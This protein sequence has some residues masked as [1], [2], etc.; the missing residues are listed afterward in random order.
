MAGRIFI[1]YRR[2]DSS[3]TAGRLNDRLALEFG[4]KSLFMDVDNMPAGVDFVAHLNTRVAACDVFLAVIGPHWLEAKDASGRRRLADPDDYVS[5]E[6]A[7]A[8]QRDIRVIPVL[9][10]GASV[11]SSDELPEPLKPLTRRHAIEVRNSHFGRDAEA[12]AEKVREALTSVRSGR[13][14]PA[15]TAAAIAVVLAVGIAIYEFGLP[16]WMPNLMPL[17]SNSADSDRA[18]VGANVKRSAPAVTD[19]ER[20]ATAAPTK[21]GTSAATL[22]DTLL[23]R[24][25]AYSVAPDIRQIQAQRFEEA[26]VHKAIAVSPEAHGLWSVAGWPTAGEA[27]V[28]ALEGCQIQYGAPCVLIA[29]DDKITLDAMS[30]RVRDMARVRYAA[31]FDLR[32]IPKARDAL[33]RRPEVAEYASAPQP[34]AAALHAE[35]D[36]TFITV[37]EAISQYDAEEQ[38]LAKC[39][40]IPKESGGPCFL[41]AVGNQVVLPQRATKPLTPRLLDALLARMAAYSVP[42][43]EQQTD[44]ETFIAEGAHKAI[45]VSPETHH[46]FRSARWPSAA[47]AETGALEGCQI[48]Y[49]K[50]CVL[51]ATDDKISADD[52]NARMPRDMPRVRYAGKFDPQQIPRARGEFLWRS[53]VANYAAAPEPKAAAFHAY[54]FPNFAMVTG[55]S[56]Q[57][58][59]EEQ[60]L[61]NC[62]AIP[63]PLDNPC[64]LYAVGNQVVLPQRSIKPLSKPPT[65]A[66]RLASL[67]VVSDAAEAVAQKYEKESSPKAL[68][69]A[70]KSHLT[71][72]VF[73]RANEQ[74]AITSVL[75]GCQVY[76]GEPCT[77]VAVN[78]RIEPATGAGHG[79]RD[80]PRTR[81][82]DLFEPAQIP[83]SDEELWRREDVATYRSASGPK[84]AA[85]HPWGR[86][87]VVKA[88]DQFRAEEDALAKCNSDPERK[89]RDGGC[90]LYAIGDQVVLP[91]R[92]RRPL[93]PRQPEPIDKK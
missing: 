74:A 84:A 63:K 4:R 38:A 10:D 75:E 24:M 46:T 68:A 67:S 25:A 8:L 58:D 2:D 86:L 3:A 41:Y 88:G 92:S 77:L 55:A 29:T 93:T 73:S 50:P 31:T 30:R 5:I 53:D 27:E 61:A 91:Q 11:P 40:A 13:R 81:Y 49:G 52:Q 72:R 36:P 87:F 20:S 1:N 70:I 89:G 26:S 16:R 14:W 65:L 34:K 83:N 60:A 59:A 33:L 19:A 22:R 35:G 9:V 43:N 90:F 32:Q 15:A 17:G 64:F 48:Q 82:A 85:Y 21:N 12:L 80:M 71:W 6:I 45:A 79:P 76:Y 62:N 66:A 28:A 57:F 44:A 51:L 18:K 7:A 47:E 54:G 69:V 23:E 39:N 42:A 37:T 78:D 56:N